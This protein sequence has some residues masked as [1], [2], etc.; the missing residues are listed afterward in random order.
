MSGEEDKQYVFLC[1]ECGVSLRVND[2]MKES[3]VERGCVICATSVTVEA[4]TKKNSAE[5]P[6]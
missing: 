6:S 4:F 1:P 5:A 2:S 3:I